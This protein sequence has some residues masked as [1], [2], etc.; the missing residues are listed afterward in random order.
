LL[1]KS[2]KR[3]KTGI[4][5]KKMTKTKAQNQMLAMAEVQIST[6]GSRH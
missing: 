2:K 3:N 6:L 4:K 5:K 1:K